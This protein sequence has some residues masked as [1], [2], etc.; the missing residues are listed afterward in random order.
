MLDEMIEYWLNIMENK[1]LVTGGYGLV[2]SEFI[3]TNI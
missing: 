2:G 3:G 1:I